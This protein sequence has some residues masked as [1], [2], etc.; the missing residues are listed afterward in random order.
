MEYRQ[1]GSS[2]LKLSSLTLGTMTFGGAGKF[3]T[4]GG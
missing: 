2:G 3:A 1:L 4:S